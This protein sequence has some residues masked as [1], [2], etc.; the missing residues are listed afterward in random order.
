MIV[1]PVTDRKQWEN[2]IQTRK[3]HTF[4]HD[5][6]WGEVQKEL[7]FKIWRFGVFDNNQLASLA[8]VIK[9]VARRGSFLFIPHGPILNENSKETIGIFS[10]YFKLLAREER[11]SF[12]RISSLMEDTPHYHSLFHEL[13]YRSAPIHMHPE[14]AWV[15]DLKKNEETLLAEMRKNTRY[16]IRKAEKDGVKVEWTDDP[17]RLID[18]FPVY[19]E[20]V[21][22]QNFTP[23]NRRYL[24]AE[25][26]IMSAA[27][28]ALLFTATH[29]GQV[30]SVAI[31]IFNQ[32]SA[33]YHHGA[34]SQKNP[35]LTASH[36]LQWNVIRE[37][38]R[39]GCDMY[40]FW[41]IAAPDDSK[42]PWA[43]L[44]RFKMGFGG[45]AE[46]YLHAQDMALKPSY[47]LNYGI[48]SL[49]RL[50]RGL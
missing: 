18:F 2:F 48:E 49:R 11:C 16:S 46:S 17:S 9:I 41:G 29:D 21:E 40:N 26:R 43:G 38:K 1:R 6:E 36:L 8:L 31:I 39:R 19:E 22:R 47:W 15:L 7:G 30:V 42:H 10:D 4:L 13:G 24:E 28:K 33:F 45:H 27:K 50:R 23:F 44:T 25:F 14:L 3:P 35:Q 12:F 32:G 20:T 37:A 5:W 34:S